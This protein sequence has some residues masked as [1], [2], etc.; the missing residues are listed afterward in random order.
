MSDALRWLGKFP[1]AWQAEDGRWLV[2][3]SHLTHT[4]TKP[5]YHLVEDINLASVNVKPPHGVRAS[6]GLTPVAVRVTR[7]VEEVTL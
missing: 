5:T 4:K 2:V 3:D 1:T 7:I 6:W